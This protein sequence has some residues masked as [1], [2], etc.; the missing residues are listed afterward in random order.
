MQKEIR[1]EWNDKN[2]KSHADGK[3]DQKY[4]DEIGDE[5]HGSAHSEDSDKV[6]K[7]K[8]KNLKKRI[9]LVWEGRKKTKINRNQTV[10]LRFFGFL[11][12]VT[13][14]DSLNISRTVW[15]EESFEYKKWIIRKGLTEFLTETMAWT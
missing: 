3:G 11:E 14:K 13:E 8:A 7:K 15:R 6:L 4:A 2:Q 5:D 10:H 1:L 12:A 9:H